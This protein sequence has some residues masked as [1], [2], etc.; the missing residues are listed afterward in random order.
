[1]LVLARVQSFSAKP[2]IMR[3]K[4]NLPHRKGIALTSSSLF[5][6]GPQFKTYWGFGRLMERLTN[7]GFS[8]GLLVWLVSIKPHLSNSSAA[9]RP[10]A[11]MH[12]PNWGAHGRRLSVQQLASPISRTRCCQ[13]CD[14]N[15]AAKGLGNCFSYEANKK[16]CGATRVTPAS[17]KILTLATYN[18]PQQAYL[19]QCQVIS[20]S[21]RK[22]DPFWSHA[23]LRQRTSVTH[24]FIQ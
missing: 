2:K 12:L 24:G 22:N 6:C 21:S 16:H 15:V 3:L 18:Q 10:H 23:G 5:K 11:D 13:G 20:R 7:A 14:Q 1:M 19:W 8:M 4:D 9:V 17:Y